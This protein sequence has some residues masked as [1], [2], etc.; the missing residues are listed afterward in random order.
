MLNLCDITDKKTPFTIAQARIIKA[1]C[2]T[3]ASKVF[4]KKFYFDVLI[5]L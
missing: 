3:F 2:S 4:T 5:A 1:L